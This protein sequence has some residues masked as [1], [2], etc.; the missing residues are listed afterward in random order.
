L[1]E[2]KLRTLRTWRRQLEGI[3]TNI[4]FDLSEVTIVNIDVVRFFAGCKEK[5]I[6]LLDCSPY[7]REWTVR[8]QDGEGLNPGRGSA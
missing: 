1:A 5:G 8:E 4:V 3:E 7:I 2:F 6:E